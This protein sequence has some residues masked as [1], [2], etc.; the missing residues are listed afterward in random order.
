[1]LIGASKDEQ[2]AADLVKKAQGDDSDEDE[3]NN[4]EGMDL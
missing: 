1:M 4:E 2:D 3:K